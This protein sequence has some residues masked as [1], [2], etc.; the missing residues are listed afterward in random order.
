MKSF[1]LCLL[2]LLNLMLLTAQL[3][4]CQGCEALFGYHLLPHQ[5]TIPAFDPAGEKL[6]IR[7]RVF[8][9]NQQ[10]AAGVIL[11]IYHTDQS[12]LYANQTDPSFWGSVHGD[13][14]TWIQS[15]S[16]GRYQFYTNRPAGYP[17]RNDPAHIHIFVQLPGHFPTYIDVIEFDDDP[18]LTP[19][20]RSQRNRRGGSGILCLARE[21]DWWIG[22]RDIYLKDV[23]SH[24]HGHR[25]QLGA[26]SSRL[27]WKGTKMQGL[28]K[29]E[30]N[31]AVKT[32]GWQFQSG[33][34]TNGF[35]VFDLRE[36]N[37]TDI[38]AH[39]IVPRRRLKAHLQSPDFFDV[40]RFPVAWF[41]LTSSEHLQDDQYR[42]SGMLHLKGRSKT[43][44]T[45]AQ[46]SDNQSNM[47][48]NFSLHLKRSDWGIATA[49][50]L[51][52]LWLDESILLNV[53]L[54]GE[55]E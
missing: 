34:L 43:I 1:C 33:E 17:N 13:R 54:L 32:G 6:C 30:G 52:D 37:I 35:A 31:I 36:I 7:G 51:E 45:T 5:D 26:E 29:H 21:K 11:Y 23:Y 24:S 44:S 9:S 8:D 3:P 14:R 2:F 16:L 50:G 27:A 25:F 22:E 10:A 55:R 15:D 28:G 39:E 49:N 53:H 18:R 19:S 20:I 40:E 4:P 42:L 47:T 41:Q 46:I 48:I 38:P 12:G